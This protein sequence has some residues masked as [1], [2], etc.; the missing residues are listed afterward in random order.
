MQLKPV[1]LLVPVIT[2]CIFSALTFTAKTAQAQTYVGSWDLATIGGGYD[3][4]DNPYIWTNNPQVYSG[5]EAAALLFGGT[6][7]QYFISTIDSDPANINH[8][9]FVDGYADVQYLLAPA[10]EAF[11]LQTS[12][13]Y[14]TPPAYSAY[15]VDHTYTAGVYVNYAFRVEATPEPGTYA[16]L[17]SAGLTGGMF[18]LRRKRKK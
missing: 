17:A 12:G 8:L 11:S 6:P 5:V 13:G 9:A 3:N 18:L 4:P 1:Q 10:S 16:M 14:Y 7:D 15:V 2:A